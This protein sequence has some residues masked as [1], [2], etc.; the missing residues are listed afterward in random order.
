MAFLNKRVTWTGR[1]KLVNIH[2][3]EDLRDEFSQRFIIYIVS[4]SL[5]TI[6]LHSQLKEP[7]IL[8]VYRENRSVVILPFGTSDNDFNAN[9]KLKML[10]SCHLT[11]LD[12]PK[13]PP[14]PPPLSEIDNQGRSNS[15]T[16]S[17]LS[18]RASV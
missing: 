14:P 18:L 3:C 10:C 4:V 1:E 15:P 2:V 12:D 16:K 8:G 13:Y 17:I 7:S 9:L 5:V 11:M 6:C